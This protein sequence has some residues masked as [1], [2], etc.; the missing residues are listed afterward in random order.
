MLGKFLLLLL[1]DI[2]KRPLPQSNC[3]AFQNICNNV[4]ECY[5]IVFVADLEQALFNCEIFLRITFTT[6]FS[7]PTGFEK[8]VLKTIE[9]IDCN[10]RQF[11]PKILKRKSNFLF[12][13]FAFLLQC[14]QFTTVTLKR[15]T[16]V[17]GSKMST[18][19][20]TGP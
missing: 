4:Q 10:L 18:I 15:R 7:D 9:K 8:Q 14:P 16:S 6:D 1:L 5:S 17:S 12:N 11:A 3:T 20:S 19:S 13:T 2:K